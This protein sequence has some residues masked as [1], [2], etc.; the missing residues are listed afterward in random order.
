MRTGIQAAISFDLLSIYDVGVDLSEIRSRKL[1]F[2]E[3]HFFPG[4]MSD[5]FLPLY[6]LL[7]IIPNTIRQTKDL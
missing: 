3:A 4:G 7:L 2:Q 5:E 1:M 6:D